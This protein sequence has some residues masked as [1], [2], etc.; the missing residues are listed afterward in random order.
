MFKQVGEGNAAAEHRFYWWYVV[1]IQTVLVTAYVMPMYGFN[2]LIHPVNLIFAPDNPTNGWPGAF[3]GGTIFFAICF[4]GLLGWLLGLFLKTNRRRWIGANLIW[5]ACLVV[6]GI[7][8]R[9]ES[10]TLLLAGFAFPIG[11]ATGYIFSQM[12]A[13]LLG[14]GRHMGHV[15]MQSGI[16]GLMFGLWGAAFSFVAPLTIDKWGLEWTLYGTALVVF[17]CAILSS[18]GFI[19]PTPPP[20]DPA[21]PVQK[22]QQPLT[23]PQLLSSPTYWIFL[24]FFL[25]FFTPGFGFKVIVQA[26]AEDVYKVTNLTASLVAVAFL[27][28]YGISRLICGLV[29][30]HFRLKPMFLFFASGQAILLL[31]AAIG[32]PMNRHVL[33]ITVMMCLVGSLFAAG[34][35]LWSMVMLTLFGPTSF[36]HTMT[37]SLPAFGLAGML[38]PV[39]LNWALRT[40]NVVAS[41]SLWLYIMAGAL[42]VATFLFWLLRRF[43]FE[44]FEHQRRQAVHLAPHSR[45]T[46]DRF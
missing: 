46:L 34:K 18:L 31:I 41:T 33:F 1:P 19:L 14:W 9:I 11:I 8:I 7:A 10:L 43:D 20:V 17:T 16:A 21:K 5:A 15:G 23:R 38:G 12:M 2:A 45:D 42:A 32:L 40:D 36:A 3:G 26:L 39:T 13:H 28:C 30:D 4:A 25:I 6:G 22:A 24:I 35:S 27:V 44:A 29:A 37:V